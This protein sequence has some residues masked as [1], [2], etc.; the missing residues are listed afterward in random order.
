MD[1]KTDPSKRI[2]ITKF[3]CYRRKTVK[4]MDKIICVLCSHE[5]K[6]NKPPFFPNMVACQ[7]MAQHWEKAN[8]F[9][10]KNLFALSARPCVVYK[11]PYDIIWFTYSTVSRQITHPLSDSSSHPDTSI[12]SKL[13]NPL[14]LFIFL[15]ALACFY[16]NASSVL[17]DCHKNI[18][19]P[20]VS[21][22]LG[23]NKLL[24]AGHNHRAKCFIKI[25]SV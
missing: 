4:E 23:M 10:Q 12:P 13:F 25:R 15:W 11:E 1:A 5:K 9:S 16:D 3:H 2:K 6:K 14:T 19:L 8:T 24:H 21:C 20:K 17:H 18:H 7:Q 22:K